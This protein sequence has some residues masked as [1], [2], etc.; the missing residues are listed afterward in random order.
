MSLK[1]SSL[2]EEARKLGSTQSFLGVLPGFCIAKGTDKDSFKIL[3]TFANKAAFTSIFADS[4]YQFKLY[5]VKAEPDNNNMVKN[6]KIDANLLVDQTTDLS[7]INNINLVE[8]EYLIQ[9]SNDSSDLA[10]FNAFLLY[11]FNPSRSQ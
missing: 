10:L 2:N 8:A 3:F 5:S 9:V 6:D 7:E 1:I 11:L 4:V